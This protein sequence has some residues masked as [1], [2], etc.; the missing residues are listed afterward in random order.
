LVALVISEVVGGTNIQNK[1]A[2]VL[3]C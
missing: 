1:Q 3:Q 2:Y